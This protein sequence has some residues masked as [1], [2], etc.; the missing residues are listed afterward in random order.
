M[1]HHYWFM[2][3][4]WANSFWM[5]HHYW[6]MVNFGIATI[7]KVLHHYD[8]NSVCWVFPWQNRRGHYLC[9]SKS[10]EC[11]WQDCY[12]CFLFLTDWRQISYQRNQWSMVLKSSCAPYPREHA[13][14]S[15]IYSWPL[16]IFYSNE[17][18]GALARPPAMCPPCHYSKQKVLLAVILLVFALT[19]DHLWCHDVVPWRHVTSWRRS[20]TSWRRAVT[21][22]DVRCHDKMALCNLHRSH[23]KEKVEKSRFST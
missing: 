7:F 11:H 15:T 5:T 12:I 4:F 6:F 10:Q 17:N 20:V 14:N 16:M 2:V 8:L 9:F 18:A 23:H 22:H 1:T 21:S 13:W 19:K 3:H